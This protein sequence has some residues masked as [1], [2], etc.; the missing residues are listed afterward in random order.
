M[1]A[2]GWKVGRWIGGVRDYLPADGDR[3]GADATLFAG[4]GTWTLEFSAAPAE[5]PAHSC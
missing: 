1:S 5:L 4:P 2:I 3:Y